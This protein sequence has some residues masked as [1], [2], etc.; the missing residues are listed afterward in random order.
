[1]RA[2]IIAD[3]SRVKRQMLDILRFHEYYHWWLPHGSQIDHAWDTHESRMDHACITHM[4]YMCV[5]CVIHQWYMRDS[6]VKRAWFIS[7]TSVKHACII[8]VKSLSPAWVTHESRM[9][10]AWITDESRTSHARVTHETRI[11]Y[12][13][14]AWL[15]FWEAQNHFHAQRRWLTHS[16]DETR[17]NSACIT[18]GSRTALMSHACF[19]HKHI[20]T[21]DPC[22]FVRVTM[23]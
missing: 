18:D 20:C 19:T 16:T 10:P 17:M 23:P 13:C 22:E 2:N 8:A 1:M 5:S 9:V 14:C 21:R 6:S 7:E 11:T 3:G 15:W 12:Q 4:I